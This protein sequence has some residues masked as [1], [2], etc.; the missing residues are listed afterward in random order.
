MNLI[1]KVIAWI[2]AL[3]HKSP[4]KA[5]MRLFINRE[6]VESM[7]GKIDWDKTSWTK[8]EREGNF[9]EY[10]GSH[11]LHR[12]E[13][14]NYVHRVITKHLKTKPPRIIIYGNDWGVK[15]PVRRRAQKK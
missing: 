8:E 12:E 9:Q 11:T 2:Y 10:M 14:Y 6:L 7:V 5:K 15:S 3:M 1:K 13:H 4:P